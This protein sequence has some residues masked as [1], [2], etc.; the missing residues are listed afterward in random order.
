MAPNLSVRG[1]RRVRGRRGH[2]LA[3]PSLAQA[4]T[5]TEALNRVVQGLR[6][7]WSSALVRL[8]LKGFGDFGEQDRSGF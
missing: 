7:A 3:F 5:A 4:A 2:G 6:C 1:L 8:G